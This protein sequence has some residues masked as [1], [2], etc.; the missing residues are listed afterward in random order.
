MRKYVE[1]AQQFG[2][3]LDV[4]T[5]ETD[6]AWNAEICAQKNSHGVPADKIQGMIDRYEKFTSID[7]IL[8]A[9]PPAPRKPKHK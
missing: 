4:Q 5:S 7:D 2:Y 6:W 1:M 9:E 3:K 8:K